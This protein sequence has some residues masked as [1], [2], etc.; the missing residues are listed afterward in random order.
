MWFKGSDLTVHNLVF[1]KLSN[2]EITAPN[3]KDIALGIME[4]NANT[5]LAQCLSLI[6]IQYLLTFILL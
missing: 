4:E 3:Q 1:Y 5:Y 6:G 2:V